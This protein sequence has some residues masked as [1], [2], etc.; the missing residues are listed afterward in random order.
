MAYSLHLTT[1]KRTS[2][3][4]YEADFFNCSQQGGQSPLAIGP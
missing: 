1:H 2:L 4:V 3:I